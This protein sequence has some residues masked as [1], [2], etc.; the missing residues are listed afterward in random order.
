MDCTYFPYSSLENEGLGEGDLEPGLKLPE[1]GFK[2]WLSMCLLT[3]ALNLETLSDKD[4]N[5]TGSV[6]ATEMARKNEVKYRVQ[7]NYWNVYLR[8][9]EN[10]RRIDEKKKHENVVSNTAEYR[11]SKTMNANRFQVRVYRKSW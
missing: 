8:K 9:L 1:N 3:F 6:I 11:E 7:T 10:W 5:T 4:S 2:V